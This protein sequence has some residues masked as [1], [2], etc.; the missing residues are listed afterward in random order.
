MCEE[1]WRADRSLSLYEQNEWY[2]TQNMCPHKKDMVLSRGILGTEDDVPKVACPQHK[3]TF[4]LE[5][6]RCL[7]DDQ[8][9]ISTYPIRV[10]DGQVYVLMPDVEDVGDTDESQSS[11]VCEHVVGV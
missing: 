3:K 1:R 11:A 7:N 5:D 6:G 4:S 8:F 10:S 9:Q 2:A